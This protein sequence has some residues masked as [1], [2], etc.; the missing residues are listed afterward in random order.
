MPRQ[1]RAL[2]SVHITAEDDTEARNLADKH[3]GSLQ[4]DGGAVGHME[5]VGE[6]AE[7]SMRITRVVYA[8][9]Q[10]RHQL[11]LDWTST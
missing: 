3:A 2:L 8:T 9:P 5:L 7:G 11:P 10:F 4:I 1:Y 6:L